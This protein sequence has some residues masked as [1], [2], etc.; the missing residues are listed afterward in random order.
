M[1]ELQLPGQNILIV[2]L[3]IMLFGSKGTI[4]DSQYHVVFHTS[5]GRNVYLVGEYQCCNYKEKR[6][7]KPTTQDHIENYSKI[8]YCEKEMEKEP[9]V[10][11]V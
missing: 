8:Y 7:Q 10:N 4:N 5:P 1:L 6:I 11:S 2:H 9:K 3:Q